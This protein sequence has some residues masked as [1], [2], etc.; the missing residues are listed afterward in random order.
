MEIRIE[1]C[2]VGT[3]N[4]FVDAVKNGCVKNIQCF[5]TEGEAKAFA[6]TV[7]DELARQ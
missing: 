4:W 1:F 7:S 6:A 2:Q 3:H 5:R